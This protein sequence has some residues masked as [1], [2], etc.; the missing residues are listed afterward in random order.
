MTTKDAQYAREYWR[1]RI[2]AE[3]SKRNMQ[4]HISSMARLGFVSFFVCPDGYT[5]EDK[6]RL[7]AARVMAEGMG[8]KVG[9][10]VR[11]HDSAKAPVAQQGKAPLR[12]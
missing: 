10:F 3:H 11:K 8:Y 9:A 2:D 12:M 1:T 4:Q 7:S 5:E 6:A